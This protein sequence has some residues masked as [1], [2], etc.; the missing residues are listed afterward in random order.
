MTLFKNTTVVY[1]VPTDKQGKMLLDADGDGV[2]SK[3]DQSPAIKPTLNPLHHS[4]TTPNPLQEEVLDLKKQ[5]QQL[6]NQLDQKNLSAIR[7][8]KPKSA[9]VNLHGSIPEI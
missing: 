2:L 1:M 6:Q 9:P 8:M 3:D 5:I 4:S 7:P